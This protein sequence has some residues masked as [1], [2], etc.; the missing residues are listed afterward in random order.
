MT[1]AVSARDLAR[2]AAEEVT[3]LGSE[4]DEIELLVQQARSE[5]DR[6]EAKRAQ[7]QER[8]S[9]LTTGRPAAPGEIREA[10]EAL[11]AATRRASLMEA[12][13]DVLRGKQR[14]LERFRDRLRFYA[15]ALAGSEDRSIDGA[16]DD[17]L[18][19]NQPGRAI[20]D[21]Q[22]DLRRDIARAMH[23][24]PAQSLTNIALQAQIVQRL[25]AQDTDRAVVEVAQLV[26]MVQQTLEAT[27][28]FIFD[29]RP[30]VLDD[31]GIV[32]TLRRTA[33]DRSRSARVPVEF[34]S[35]GADRRLGPDLESALFRIV[36]DAITGYLTTNPARISVHLEWTD[37]GLH[38]EV[39][40]IPNEQ[41]L[42]AIQAGEAASAAAVDLRSSELGADLP[43]ALAAMI[44]EQRIDASAAAAAARDEVA[45]AG[46]LPIDA[47]RG[48]AQRAR[49]VGVRAQQQDEGAL[50][51]LDVSY[52]A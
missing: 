43:P 37:L 32:P 33:R 8:L 49:G 39:R 40:G 46:A 45:R 12:Q 14:V 47:W 23:D 16:D 35:I 6:H 28:T 22:E 18:D 3:R 17:G 30:M 48:I 41:T 5:A 7:L 19:G 25:V 44:R 31:L 38:G 4:L 27:K 15:D 42:Q 26:D 21:A 20:R 34:D 52:P 13:V 36:D 10:T 24:G 11:A 51:V 29:V 50:L 2:T 1:D 9:Q